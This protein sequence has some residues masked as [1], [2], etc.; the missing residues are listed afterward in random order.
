MDPEAAPPAD[1]P[2][3]KRALYDHAACGL[4]LTRDD[5]TFV[6]VNRTFCAWIGY[7]E[8]DLVD[9]LHLQDLLTMGARIFHQTHWSPLLQIQGSIGEV[10][11]DLVHRDRRVIPMIMNA[12][13]RTAGAE[14]RHEIAVFVAEDRS[15]YER[16]LLAA[17]KRAEELLKK[18]REA[19]LALAAAQVELDLQRVAAEDR[20]RFAEQMVG[21]VSHDLRN[22]IAAIQLSAALIGRGELTPRQGRALEAISSSVARSK[23]LIEDLLDFTEARI[24]RGLRVKI[25]P[26][27]LHEF[28][29]QVVEEL[30]VLF[31]GRTLVHVAGDGEACAGDEDRLAQMLGNLVSNA[32]TYGDPAGRVT[33]STQ[34]G[35]DVAMLAVHNH[36]RPIAA[37]ALPTLFDAM[38]RG[39][40]G[41]DGA[42]D[43]GG[44]KNGHS[45]GL[46]LFIVRQIARAHGG[47]VAVAS[48]A[49]AGTT[50]T[51]SL[52]R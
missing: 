27:R 17:R 49:D 16:E 14:A 47:D 23:R 45:V 1:G 32:M 41:D 9:R 51:V 34:V 25:Q 2:L 44:G 19:Q 31:P 6:L 10:K 28:T 39:A 35:A 30:R 48:S 11:L 29:A 33:V 24:G 37:D 22:P 8:E 43:D 52:P 18:E 7:G 12:V 21:I 46:G 15:R 50:F 40:V 36:G 4:I 42:G 5:G 20:A 13:R 3:D 38:T 26:L